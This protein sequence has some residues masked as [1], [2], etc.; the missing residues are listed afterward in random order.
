MIK[1]PVAV[2]KENTALRITV[3]TLAIKV[4]FVCSKFTSKNEQAG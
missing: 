3:R 2:I 1:F 4:P